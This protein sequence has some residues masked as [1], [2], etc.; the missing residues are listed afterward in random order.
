MLILPLVGM[1]TLALNIQ[2]VKAEPRTWIV[3]DDGPADFHTIQEAINTAS[4]GDTVYVYN[5]TYSENLVLNKTV[6]LVGENRS[7]TILDGQGVGTVVSIRANDVYINGFTIR[8]SGPE[9]LKDTG[10]YLNSSRNIVITGNILTNNTSGVWLEK[11]LNNAIDENVIANS[12]VHGIYLGNS[13]SNAFSGNTIVNSDYGIWL[14]RFSN[15]NAIRRN[16]VMG[17]SMGISLGWKSE[18]NTVYDNIVTEN[19]D[20]V[21]L[22]LSFNNYIYENAIENNVAGIHSINSDRTIICR[23]N[24]IGNMFHARTID[25]VQ[26]WHNGAEG[27][28]WSGYRGEDADH[29]GIGDDPYVIDEDNND[30]YP[31]MEPWSRFRVFNVLLEGETYHVTTLSNSTVASFNYNSSMKEVSFNVTGPS[32]ANGFCNVTIPKILLEKP[33]QVLIDRKSMIEEAIITGNSTHTSTCLTYSFGTHMI[34]ISGIEP[35]DK[36]PPV[37]NAGDDQTVDEDAFVTF[38]GAQSHDDVGIVSY[39]WTFVDEIAK[40]LDGIKANYTFNTPG[41]YNVTLTVI[42][43]CGN[44][45]TDAVTIT[46]LDV[47]DPVAD[48]GQDRIIVQGASVSFDASNSSDNVGIVSYEWDFGDGANGMGLSAS[49]TYP[50]PGTYTVTLT[51]RDEAG[52]AG[53]DSI[54]VRVLSHFEV[55]PWWILGVLAVIGIVIGA[56]LFWRHKH[57][58]HVQ[59]KTSTEMP[60]KQMCER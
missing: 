4:L 25:S 40:T 22:S 54:T 20:G 33:L 30:T 59:M 5:G 34:R 15:K 37:A 35:K 26:V 16:T 55:F 24:F 21:Y 23:N 58:K 27:N 43:G 19:D 9:R 47:T 49:H 51:V 39:E 41:I 31:L 10:I 45:D 17:N 46:V 6:T 2:S 53:T 11:A 56:T 14:E 8:G 7:T 48:A 60:K 18:G 28:Y 50:N 38:D 13:S 29:N 32:G 36:V 52:H 57:R 1:L 12:T 42:D 44:W 3:D